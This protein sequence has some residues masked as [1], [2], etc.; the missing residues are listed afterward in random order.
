MSEE[1]KTL[2]KFLDWWNNRVKGPR[3]TNEQYERVFERLTGVL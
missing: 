3:L 2:D 1:Q